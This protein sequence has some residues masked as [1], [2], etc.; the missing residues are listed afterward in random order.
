M[1]K[2]EETWVNLQ[3]KQVKTYMKSKSRKQTLSSSSYFCR[4]VLLERSAGQRAEF[5]RNSTLERVLFHSIQRPLERL[6]LHA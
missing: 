3:K 6:T 4:A 1:A 5:V 2:E